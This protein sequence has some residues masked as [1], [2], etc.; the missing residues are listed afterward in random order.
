MDFTNP[1]LKNP[2]FSGL[3]FL[4]SISQWGFTRNSVFGSAA[5]DDKKDED[6]QTECGKMGFRNNSQN[7]ELNQFMINPKTALQNRCITV[8]YSGFT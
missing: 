2:F 5:P 7:K 8:A 1:K 3:E 4:K 6:V